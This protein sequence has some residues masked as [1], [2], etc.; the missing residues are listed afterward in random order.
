M[1]P[2]SSTPG[3]VAA[4]AAAEPAP[5]SVAWFRRWEVLL[6]ITLL[7]LIGALTGGWFASAPLSKWAFKTYLEKKIAEGYP[8]D[9]AAFVREQREAWLAWREASPKLRHATVRLALYG[10][11]IAE[12]EFS[13]GWFCGAPRRGETDDDV[14]SKMLSQQS[15]VAFNFPADGNALSVIH[16]DENIT[17]QADFYAAAFDIREWMAEINCYPDDWKEKVLPTLSHAGLMESL[18]GIQNRYLAN[19]WR[20]LLGIDYLGGSL[21]EGSHMLFQ[22]NICYLLRGIWLMQGNADK[23]LDAW[24]HIYRKG[25]ILT[26]RRV[27]DVYLLNFAIRSGLFRERHLTRL[28]DA[29]YTRA[30]DLRDEN[31]H[32][33]RQWISMMSPVFLKKRKPG[34]TSYQIPDFAGLKVLLPWYEPKKA[35]DPTLLKVFPSNVSFL[36]YRAE[37]MYRED[38]IIRSEALRGT[39]QWAGHKDFK[40]DFWLGKL[41]RNTKSINSIS[42]NISCQELAPC[43]MFQ[44]VLGFGLYRARTGKVPQRLE[45]FITPDIA[46]RMIQVPSAALRYTI[47]ARGVARLA[48]VLDATVPKHLDF[49]SERGGFN[50]PEGIIVYNPAD[51][52]LEFPLDPGMLKKSKAEKEDSGAAP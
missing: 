10:A 51:T 42:I 4:S 24:E 3:S 38:F 33:F 45:D 22:S 39:S 8:S 20:N 9:E 46:S 2:G 17:A 48:Y 18:P 40:Y 29:P 27:N 7:C 41:M 30:D 52:P 16:D 5:K 12:L 11:K 50:T 26:P 13:P 35:S 44:A 36:V 47:D 14:L 49:L 1:S 6:A 28:M 21:P 19:R 31:A 25:P 34:R 43:N 23:A 37:C 32:H 15:Q